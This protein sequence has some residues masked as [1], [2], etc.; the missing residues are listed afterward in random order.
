M[1]YWEYPTDITYIKENGQSYYYQQEVTYEPYRWDLMPLNYK[2]GSYS[3]EQANAVAA[4]MWNIGA[5][6]NMNYGESSGAYSGYALQQMNDL[7]GFS[8]GC[9]YIDKEFY[10]WSEWKA[11]L[12]AELDAGRPVI[13]DGSN[14]EGGHAFICDGYKEN[15][16]FHINWGWGGSGN[17]YFLL[18][19]LDPE[20]GNDPYSSDI[21]MSIGIR[22]PIQGESKVLEMRYATLQSTALPAAN[23]NF[24]VSPRV[25]NTGNTTFSGSIGIAVLNADGSIKK[26]IHTKAEYLVS[27]GVR[28][29]RDP[30]ISCHLDEA[31]AD[32]EVILPIF[33]V[34]G[35]WQVMRGS[36]TAPLYIDKNGVQDAGEDLPG[37][38]EEKPTNI[39]IYWN[40]F[41]TDYIG[42]SQKLSSVGISY[43]IV[44]ATEDIVLRYTLKDYSSWAGKV[45]LATRALDSYEYTPV[46]IGSDGV[47]EVKV[48]MAAYQSEGAYVNYFSV[49]SEQAGNLSFDI[50]VY[51]ASDLTRPLF[52][53][54]GNVMRFI[55]PVLSTINPAP[56]IGKP[57]EKIPFEFSIDPS[58]DAPLEGK[59]LWL[60]YWAYSTPSGLSVYYVDDQGNEVKAEAGMSID[61]GTY[62]VG[63]KY[64]FLLSSPTECSAGANAFIMMSCSLGGSSL[65]LT[66]NQLYMVISNGNVTTYPI[67]F[68]LTGIE[69]T[70]SITQIVQKDYT[71]IYFRAKPGFQ[72]PSAIKVKVNGV[73]QRHGYWYSQEK[74]YVQ[75]NRELITGPIEIEAI[76]MPEAAD[77]YT[78]TASLEGVSASPA[79][80]QQIT[81]GETLAFTLTPNEGFALPASIQVTMGGK[82]LAQGTY[83]YEDG[84]VTIPNVTGAIAITAKGIRKDVTVE[85]SN[86]LDNLF[87]PVN[88]SQVSNIYF[89]FSSLGQD[90]LFV[91]EMANAG[92]FTIQYDKVNSLSNARTLTFQNGKAIIK[93]SECRSD[94]PNNR[95]ITYFRIAAKEAGEYP[96][97]I[98]VYDAT[99]TVLYATSNHTLKTVV[100]VALSI[101]NPIEGNLKNGQIPFTITVDNASAWSG[102]NVY[103]GVDMIY[104]SDAALT[105][106]YGDKRIAFEQVN[107]QA[108]RLSERLPLSFKKGTYNLAFAGQ[109]PSATNAYAAFSLLDE[110][111]VYIP[112]STQTETT[113]SF[114]FRYD[115]DYGNVTNLTVDGVKQVNKG[116]KLSFTL[117][118]SGVYQLPGEITVTMGGKTLVAG[119]GYTYDSRSGKV[120]IPSVT[121]DVEITAQGVDDRHFEAL[122]TSEGVTFDPAS[123]KPVEVGGSITL[124]LAPAEGYTLPLEVTVKMGDKVLVEGTDYT[125]TTNGEKATLRLD[126]VNGKIS[127]SAKATVKRYTVSATG[128]THMKSD[129]P[130][131]K[132][133][134]HNEAYSFTLTPDADYLLPGEI[135]ITIG[136]KEAAL[137]TDYTYNA[138]TGEVKL[139]HVTGNVVILAEAMP[140]PTYLITL[141]ATNVDAD[142]K[143]GSVKQGGNFTITL[144]AVAGYRL[145]KTV[146]VKTSDG[147]FENFTYE[148]GV[149][150]LKNVNAN[151]T[152]TA[153]GEKIPTYQLDV[154]SLVHLTFQREGSGEILEGSALTGTLKADEGYKLPS[155]IDVTVNGVA[156]KDYTYDAKSGKI[157]VRDVKGNVA[158]IAEAVDNQSAEVRLS[159]VGMTTDKPDRFIV[160]LGEKFELTFK[161]ASGYNLPASIKVVMGGERLTAGTDYSYDSSTGAF[162]LTEVTADV[163]IEAIGKEIP[164][165]TPDPEPEPTPETYTV[166]LPVVEGATIIAE[167]ATTVEKG[168]NLVFT[169]TLLEGYSAPELTVKANGVVLLPDAN[170]RYT[171]KN[172]TSNVVITVTGVVKGDPTGVEA[173]EAAGLRVWQADG[174]L[175][176]Y[177]PVPQRA[178]IV[179]FGGQTYATLSLPAGETVTTMPQ[180]AYII[181]VGNRPYKLRF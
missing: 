60:Y 124:A 84:K 40:R 74:G 83:T 147:L 12:R 100:P 44:N 137:G 24:V 171:V 46:E 50:Q 179:T 54:D 39:S 67:T 162:S 164:T 45:E 9:R 36:A 129:I 168:K 91:Y 134:S 163:E 110:N 70:T 143:S 115:I 92:K 161:A 1:R 82:L 17:G 141:E 152:V 81:K 61:A 178:Y 38:P 71:F 35:E 77:V 126:N 105:L 43:G 20:G 106:A 78:V 32:G 118:A 148:K 37:D 117:K 96:Y 94:E 27:V 53:Q 4:L 101:T 165:P 125:L 69:S 108:M 86:R 8:D 64:K 119:K 87:F 68:S 149:I 109:E 113:I 63:K 52:E 140:I 155:V 102:K 21:N 85:I 22:P 29:V 130:E 131:G 144:K 97:T 158:I 180:G 7:F 157:E 41:D 51:Y 48:P 169:V 6:V 93:S 2:N 59:K 122:L 66:G 159:L 154:N 128:L 65:P 103:L 114:S 58:V 150:T 73:E 90:Y 123:I 75:L 42:V 174:Q 80:P 14:S 116:G 120:E 138:E 175:H 107:E 99:G 89:N 3:E 26:T 76:G 173:A 172:V 25:I 11:V 98:K 151:L 177:T 23:T 139:L 30:A 127:I 33:E 18:T 153:V 145:P 136:D 56:V 19:A 156:Y 49:K 5:N 16:A 121:G 160:K 166:T 34:N 133:V 142:K 57:N 167:G 10:R 31:L 104:H 95:L 28:S 132:R 62:Q 170:G 15:E 112:V 111:G 135:S 13:Y 146:T 72:L 47:F 181:Y 79:L 55:Q 88:E 176:I